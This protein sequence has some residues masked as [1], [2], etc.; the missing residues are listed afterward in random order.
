MATNRALHAGLARA[1]VRWIREARWMLLLAA[2]LTVAGM[3]G[4]VSCGH[5]FDFHLVSW[6]EAAHAGHQGV[7]YPAWAQ[8]AAWQ[9]G[10]PRFIFYPPLSW[11]LGALLS[12]AFGADAASRSI[13]SWTMAVWTFVFLTLLLNGLATRRLAREWLSEGSAQLAGV[14]AIASPYALFTAFERSALAELAAGVWVPLALMLATRC[15]LR[16]GSPSRA[17]Q[18]SART[19]L[20]KPLRSLV[21]SPVWSQVLNRAALGLALTIAA[22]WLTNP[23][24]GVM[25]C[26]LLAGVALVTAWTER[27]AWPMLRALV[28]VV[29]GLG[30]AAFYLVPA[31]WEQRWINI[32]AAS[33]VGMRIEDSWLFAHHSGAE[34]AFHDAV[35]HRASWIFV[36]MVCAIV[37]AVLV[38]R[39][40][41]QLC[42]EHRTQWLPL[43]LLVP[44][45][46]AMQ[47][48]FS[49]GLW[50]LLPKAEFL[51]FPWRL[52]MLLTLPLAIFAAQALC[53]FR[54][55]AR[56]AGVTVWLLLAVVASAGWFHQRCDDEDNVAAQIAAFQG[57]GSQPTDEYAPVGA[58]NAALAAGLPTG[59][60]AAD[61]LV[62]LGEADEDGALRWS[63]QRSPCLVTVY[64][65]E[66]GPK[67]KF[68]ELDA[69][70]AGYLIVRL[71]RFPAWQIER[72]GRRITIF[73]KRTDGLIVVPVERGTNRIRIHWMETADVR[74]GRSM[75]VAALLCWLLLWMRIER[76]S[77]GGPMS[78]TESDVD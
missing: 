37:L 57:G 18:G 7:L 23:P 53:C 41:R 74:W 21:L 49:L 45:V 68:L 46:V 10:E 51:Q 75:S 56:F 55:W 8:S 6:M 30:M 24:A 64:P 62:R 72:N 26:Y 38:L 60:L 61:P 69:P 73:L 9:A 66:W 19:M 22:C 76:R 11:M 58:D 65:T 15:C 71:R 39:R 16:A 34:M 2:I 52:T 50:H 63:S 3:R 78:Y 25:I 43:L 33:D 4:S 27:S 14:L 42:V 77:A 31:A 67:R 13:V 35:L 59:C 17:E 40:S 1:L 28:A 48:P 36:L 5:D 29:L 20:G 12:N 44:V 32:R 54:R 70:Q 47:F